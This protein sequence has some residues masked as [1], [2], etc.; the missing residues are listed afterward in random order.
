MSNNTTISDPTGRFLKNPTLLNAHKL[1][2]CFH[3]YDTETGIEVSWHEISLSSFSPEEIANLSKNV[4]KAQTFSCSNILSVLKWWINEE[5]N[6]LIY[7]TETVG[8]TSIGNR[9]EMGITTCSSKSVARWAL[10]VLQ[11]LNYLH[12]QHP[13]VVHNLINLYTIYVNP[14]TMNVKIVPPRMSPFRPGERSN[15]VLIRPWMAPESFSNIKTVKSDI[16]SLGIAICSA[17]SSIEVYSECKSPYDLYKKIVTFSLP[18]AIETITDPLARDLIIMCL[19]PT[20]ERPS[21]AE[22]LVHPF[23]RQEFP[24][25]PLKSHSAI[26]FLF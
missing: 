7:I 18:N 12:C 13:P 24:K 10:G 17:L 25:Q 21:A 15:S 4:K 9:K 6:Q 22:L 5:S 14:S 2:S 16:W 1:I 8:N 3:G 11:A 20:E 23:F 26:Q 19:K